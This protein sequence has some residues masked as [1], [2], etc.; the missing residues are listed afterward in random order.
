M[1]QIVI[2]GGTCLD[3]LITNRSSDSE[4]VSVISLGSLDFLTGLTT[5]SR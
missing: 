4:T 2:G 5:R 1:G 3:V